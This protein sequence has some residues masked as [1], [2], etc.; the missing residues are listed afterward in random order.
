MLL[1]PYSERVWQDFMPK[2][3][4]EGLQGYFDSNEFAVLQS[5]E[6][7]GVFEVSADS[8]L[9]NVP[10]QIDVSLGVPSSEDVSPEDQQAF[11]LLL[12]TFDFSSLASGSSSSL[13]FQIFDLSGGDG[14]SSDD[15]SGMSAPGF[16]T[17]DDVVSHH[18]QPQEL[19]RPSQAD[20]DNRRPS[21]SDTAPSITQAQQQPVL[22]SQTSIADAPSIQLQP[23]ATQSSLPY[24]IP[25][26]LAQNPLFQ[27][28]FSK[29]ASTQRFAAPSPPSQPL[30]LPA[31]TQEPPPEPLRHDTFS[32]HSS[33]SSLVSLPVP[34]PH[35]SHS[36][37]PAH[38]FVP[39]PGANRTHTR[40]VAAS[41]K[42]P[43]PHAESAPWSASGSPGHA[44]TSSWHGRGVSAS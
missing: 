2:L 42:P 24:D 6:T 26:E 15:W 20:T 4:T 23:S 37:P 9:N 39:P 17:A 18:P 40:R 36:T 12:E 22:S 34:E 35:V 29:I 8:F 41:W 13:D 3:D 14:S 30:P 5:S 7:E 43:A 44:S 21:Q 38:T 10:D 32:R 27:D 16:F 31:Q 11:S 25:P 28:W 1:K 33:S 19:A